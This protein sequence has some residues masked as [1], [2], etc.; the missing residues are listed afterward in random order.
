[1]NVNDIS[2]HCSK[3]SGNEYP[4]V[5]VSTI[6]QSIILGISVNDGGC[7]KITFFLDSESDLINFKNSVISAVANYQRNK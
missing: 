6:P 7:D 4:R 2:I 5:R 1:M 3:F